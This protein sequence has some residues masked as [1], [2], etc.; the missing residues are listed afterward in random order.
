MSKLFIKQKLKNWFMKCNTQQNEE[1]L[2][3][4]IMYMEVCTKTYFFVYVSMLLCF[5]V[6]I[7]FLVFV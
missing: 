4:I 5:Y 2:S 7:F 6:I 3:E 1:A